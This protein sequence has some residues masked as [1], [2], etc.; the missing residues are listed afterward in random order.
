MLLDNNTLG[1]GETYEQEEME[2]QDH[3]Y[4]YAYDPEKGKGSQIA[5][6]GA[7]ILDPQIVSHGDTSWIFDEE[8]DGS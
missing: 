1:T 5:E 4:V 6:Y 3:M 7:F 8:S 2:D